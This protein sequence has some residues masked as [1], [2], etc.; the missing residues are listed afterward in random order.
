MMSNESP[1]KLPE[2]EYTF[3]RDG[4]GNKIPTA[5][6]EQWARGEITG[7]YRCPD[8]VRALDKV[9]YEAPLR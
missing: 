6:V 5:N 2:I 8:C 7:R 1:I 4:C 9:K 3:C